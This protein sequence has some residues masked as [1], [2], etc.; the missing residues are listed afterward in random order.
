M[1][2]VFSNASPGLPVRFLGGEHRGFLK[3]GVKTYQMAPISPLNSFFFFFC[4]HIYSLCDNEP[5]DDGWD[6]KEATFF[7]KF[8]LG[9]EDD[10]LGPNDLR[11]R[12][13]MMFLYES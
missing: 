3:E 7:Y 2:Y 5:R 4:L 6:G 13:F 11:M 12:T 9:D 8:N 1:H 10:A